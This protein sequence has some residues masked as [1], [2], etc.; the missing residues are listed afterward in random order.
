MKLSG[1]PEKE[2][3][4]HRGPAAVVKQLADA[5]GAE[6]LMYGGG[7]GEKATA[8]SYRAERERTA[9]MLAGFSET[10]RAKV[11]GG[12][13]ARFFGFGESR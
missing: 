11:L 8:E 4:P 6:R 1:M 10:D 12:N 13:A 2:K 7:Y 5:F 9:A 3:Y